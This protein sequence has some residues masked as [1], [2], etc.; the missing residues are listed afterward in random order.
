MYNVKS[1]DSNEFINH[2]KVLFSIE[3]AKK[4]SNDKTIFLPWLKKQGSIK[5]LHI[6]KLPF[7]WK[8]MMTRYW[9]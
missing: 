1:K 4:K 7:F 6:E 2:D 3:E 9:K 5:V 8:L